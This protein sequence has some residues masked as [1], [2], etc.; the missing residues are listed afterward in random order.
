M[1]VDPQLSGGI[2]VTVYENIIRVVGGREV[3]L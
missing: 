3:Q 2:V 1:T